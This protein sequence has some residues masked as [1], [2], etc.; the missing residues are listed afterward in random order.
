MSENERCCPE[1]LLS[2]EL[3]VCGKPLP[4]PDHPPTAE[5]ELQRVLDYLYKHG[6]ETTFRLLREIDN[7]EHW[8]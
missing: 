7:G 1:V 5:Q 4:C 8:K 6:D 2:P 3:K